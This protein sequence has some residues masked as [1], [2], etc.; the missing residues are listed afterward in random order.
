GR[1]AGQ[2][3]TV[4][5]ALARRADGVG[6]IA[7]G[8]REYFVGAGVD[9]SR[10]FRLRNPA[11]LDAPREPREHVRARLGWPDDVFVVLHTGS[12]GY[13]QGL[14]NVLRAADLAR[15]DPSLLFALQG[16]GNQRAKLEQ[17]ERRLRLPNVRF[18]P[19]ASA[20][21]FPGILC[22]ADALL[23]NQRGSVRNMSMPSKLASYFLTGVPVIAAVSP[24]DETAKEVEVSGG[25][26]VIPPERPDRLLEAVAQLRDEPEQAV[27][28]GRDGRGCAQR[29]LSTES[30]IARVDEFLEAC[31][32]RSATGVAS[33][34]GD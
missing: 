2:V 15:D 14:E 33:N 29:Y 9:P 20:K 1:V 28:L 3:R 10:I 30:A 34:L 27:R 17:E 16:D 4:E 19:I 7:D 6:I 31:V 23:V 12:M 11:R 18:R 5:T 32:A 26:V 22:A 8:Y 13:K 21:E 25:G 24:D